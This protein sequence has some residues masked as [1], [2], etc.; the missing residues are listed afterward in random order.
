ML[1]IVA[2]TAGPAAGAARVR[3]A[4]SMAQ[5][6]AAAAQAVASAARARG[7]DEKA[8]DT[9]SQSAPRLQKDTDTVQ[10]CSE[11]TSAARFL[12]QTPA[13]RSGRR[14]GPDRGIGRAPQRPKGAVPQSE[15]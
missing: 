11:R 2:A 6:S 14:P 5:T 3:S 13:R 10:Y 12:P 4:P 1:R 8:R 7:E 9:L 15:A